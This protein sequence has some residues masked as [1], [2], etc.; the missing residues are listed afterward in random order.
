[1]FPHFFQSRAK[2]EARR[3]FLK[4][5][6]ASAAAPILL[7]SRKSGAADPPVIPPS[8][9]TTPWIEYLPNQITPLQPIATLYP[10]WTVT[11]NTAGGECGRAAHQRFAELTAPEVSGTPELYYLFAKENPNWVFN[12]AYPAQP[13]W[14]YAGTPWDEASTP[15]PTVFGHYGHSVICRIYNELPEKHV[16]FGTPEIGTHL[17][18]LHTP[19]ES[20]GYPGDFYSVSKAGPTLSAPGQF[21]DHF[22]PNIY[23]GIDSFGGIGDS[24]EALGTLWYHDHTMDFTAPNVYRG[25]AGF[26]LMFDQL[27]SGNEQPDPANPAALRLP[28]HPYDYPI[29]LQDKRFDATGMLFYDQFN[30]EGILGD[31][32]TVNG[33]IEPVLRVA[34]RK[35]RLRFLNGG[36]S[37]FYELYLQNK[38][39][40]T[41]YTFTY[42]ANDGN[43]LPKPLLNQFKVRLGVAERAD[44]VVD[45]SKFPLGTELYFVNQLLQTSTRGPDNVKAPGTR[46]LKVIVDRNVP[47]S[48]P[49]VSRVPNALRPLPDIPTDFTGVPVRRWVFA[50]S[51]GMWTVNDQLFNVNQASATITKGSAEIWELVNPENGWEHP[52]HI[53]FEEG[54]IIDKIVNGISVPIPVHERGRKDVFV[55]GKNTTFRVFLRFRDFTGKY[56]MHCHN[57]IHEDHAMMV[58]WDI[59]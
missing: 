50:R 53:H 52:I 58:R 37:R 3:S 29:I 35:Y 25:L 30:P 6:T 57:L 20:D 14:G 59:V 54:R 41:L 15:G 34:R 1:M 4:L 28:S 18:N 49:D 9:P 17:H 26:Y 36:P 5:A 23:A 32:I 45:F 21:K 10:P 55:L 48:E 13:I 24:R 44:I 56:P 42:I 2:L 46:L 38:N 47:A 33:K 8:P 39:A 31:K 7:T 16:G 40:N 22:Y 11:A 51:G 43:L 19:S 27:D 12:P